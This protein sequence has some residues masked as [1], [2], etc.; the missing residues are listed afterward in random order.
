VPEA[1][2]DPF[3]AAHAVSD[4]HNPAIDQAVL[5]DFFVEGHFTRHL[6]RV[7]AAYAEKQELMLERLH[8][9]LP[10]ILEVAADPAGMH[11]VAWLPEDV[12]DVAIAERCADAGVSAPP[13]TY[14]MLERPER[15][16]LMLG[17][18]GASKPRIEVGVQQ[19]SAVLRDALQR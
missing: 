11:L 18:T 3:S 2:I 13:L 15:G 14:Y 10:D 12:D 1:L 17:Y 16:A 4:R 6:R 7:R 9:R 5:A 19:L 8:F